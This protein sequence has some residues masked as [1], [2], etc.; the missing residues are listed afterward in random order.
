MWYEKATN[1][2]SELR[3]FVKQAELAQGGPIV[4]PWEQGRPTASF[5]TGL[6]LSKGV[7]T[8]R[9]PF[10]VGCGTASAVLDGALLHFTGGGYERI[11]RAIPR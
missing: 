3:Y 7:T 6:K 5:Q 9:W 11:G 2:G 1:Q 4:P 8:T 10:E